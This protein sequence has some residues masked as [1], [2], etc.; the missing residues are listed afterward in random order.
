MQAAVPM[1]LYRDLQAGY[2]GDWSIKDLQAL[3]R[4]SDVQAAK[5]VMVSPE[6]Y[7]RWRTDRTPNPAALRLLSIRAGFLPYPGWEGWILRDG[8]LHPP[9]HSGVG[10]GSGEV[11][12]LP[13]QYQRLA[14]LESELRRSKVAV[15]SNTR[16]RSA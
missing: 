11:A 1:S 10:F 8:L 13:W 12:A 6:T 14:A 9:G 2:L 3:C 16:R 15:L 5:F 7:R 4:F